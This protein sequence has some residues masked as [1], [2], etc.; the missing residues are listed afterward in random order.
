M[1]WTRPSRAA[2][3]L[4]LAGAGLGAC[5]GDPSEP[6]ESVSDIGDPGPIHVHGLGINPA[7]GDRDRATNEEVEESEADLK[8]LRAWLA[9]IDRRDYFAASRRAEAHAAVER[10]ARALEAFEFEAFARDA[11]P[12]AEHPGPRAVEDG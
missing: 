5:G 9:K 6:S 2:L 4:V 12:A 8:R 1:M 10:C 11:R 7:D 3:E